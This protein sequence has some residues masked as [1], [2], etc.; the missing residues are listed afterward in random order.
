MQQPTAAP[1]PQRVDVAVQSDPVPDPVPDASTLSAQ[2]DKY[3]AA[4]AAAGSSSAMPPPST[5][6][7]PRSILPATRPKKSISRLLEAS[8][9]ASANKQPTVFQCIDGAVRTADQSVPVLNAPVV[10]SRFDEYIA[11]PEAPSHGENDDDEFMA[12]GIRARYTRATVND[13]CYDYISPHRTCY[14]RSKCFRIHPLDKSAYIDSMMEEG[15]RFSRMRASTVTGNAPAPRDAIRQTRIADPPPRVQLPQMNN[16]L[17]SGSRMRHRATHSVPMARTSSAGNVENWDEISG[18]NSSHAAASSSS[19]SSSDS[20]SEPSESDYGAWV[21]PVQRI[22]DWLGEEDLGCAE[23]AGYMYDPVQKKV[24]PRPSY[25]P[26]DE[27]PAAKG[28]AKALEKAAVEPA[29]IR[30]PRPRHAG[31]CREWLQNRC[32]LGYN[33]RFVHDD[34]EYDDDV[35]EPTVPAIRSQEVWT[36]TVHDHIRVQIGAGLTIEDVTTGSESPWIHVDNLPDNITNPTIERL[37]RPF[38][39]ILE[40]RRPPTMASPMNVRVHFSKASQAFAAFAAL[41]N[42]MSFGRRLDVRMAVERKQGGSMIKETAVRLDWDYAHRTVYMGYA[43]ME[44]AEAAAARARTVLY[45]GMYQTVAGVYIGIP[46]VGK[47]TV[48]FQFLPPGVTKEAME[49]FGAHQGMVTERPTYDVTMEQSFAG[50]RK[51]CKQFISTMTDL[52]FRPS[53][54][55]EGRMRAWAY[56]KSAKDAADAAANLHGRKPPYIGGNRLFARHIKTISFTLSHAK[57]QAIAPAIRAFTQRVHEERPGNSLIVVSKGGGAYMQLRLSGEDMHQLGQLKAEFERILNGEPV[58]AADGKIAWDDFFATSAGTAFLDNVRNSFRDVPIEVDALRRT[59]RVFGSSL[60]RGCAHN[61]ILEKLSEVSARKWFQ[62]PLD[63]RLASALDGTPFAQLQARLGADNLE[64]DCW[65]RVLHVR[66]DENTLGVASDAVAGLRS[67]LPYAPDVKRALTH[68]CPVCLSEASPPVAL[69]CGHAFCRACLKRYLLA[70]GAQRRFPLACLGAGATCAARIPLALAKA[71]LAVDEFN[72]L[73][74][75]A[76]ASHVAKN[77]AAFRFCP[78][79]G[80]SQ[81]YRAAPRTTTAGGARGSGR[82]GGVIVQCAACLARTCAA[83]DAPAHEGLTCG[84]AGDGGELFADWAADAG[85][86]QCPSCRMGIE[87]EAGCNHMV[88]TMCHTHI[89]WVCSKTFPNGD[90]IYKHMHAVHG[91]FGLGPVG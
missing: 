63:G 18:L 41:H 19:G 69:A 12:F 36:N 46:A 1:Q 30:H 83:C 27:P 3:I 31:R 89:C 86:K 50:L 37:L 67:R 88:C 68:E 15:A 54:Y 47:V 76:F 35:P 77:A 33:C 60:Y 11:A 39:D 85:V 10:T 29:V 59:I 48:K 9:V 8:S 5:A 49:I 45:D 4:P 51:L 20:S 62:I 16:A 44:L 79:A 2:F 34:L 22:S 70:G 58:I 80:C 17:A 84:E 75:A 53:P 24:V 73:V 72:S 90:G 74:G 82:V 14:N 55:R 61:N 78:T 42:T 66:G 40:I 32:F 64:L 56:F 23:F 6:F 87:K 81:V 13:I 38:G 26:I 28:K 43:S 52:E 65:R 91:D 21:E 25:T 71:L 57:H 7:D